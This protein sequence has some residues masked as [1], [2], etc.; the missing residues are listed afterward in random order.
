[1]VY[2]YI[3]IKLSILINSKTN[4][5]PSPLGGIPSSIYYRKRGSAMLLRT[6]D[7]TLIVAPHS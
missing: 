1:M 4:R 5:Y 7:A 2:I 3:Y 6:I